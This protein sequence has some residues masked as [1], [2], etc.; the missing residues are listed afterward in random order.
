MGKVLKRLVFLMVGV[1]FSIGFYSINVYASEYKP[2][3]DATYSLSY[4]EEDGNVTITGYSG[5]AS[6]KLVIPGEID[7]HK[8]TAIGNDVFLAV[9]T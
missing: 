1:A 9:G 3:D 8:V 6:G 7:G 2:Y 5:D 4:Y